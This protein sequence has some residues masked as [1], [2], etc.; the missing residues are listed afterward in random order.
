MAYSSERWSRG[1]GTGI[2]LSGHK[3]QYRLG[4]QIENWVEDSH[5]K[6]GK[7][8][9]AE[10]LWGDPKNAFSDETTHGNDYDGQGKSGP[11]ILDIADRK[12]LQ[13]CPGVAKGHMFSHGLDASSYEQKTHY[14]SLNSLNYAEPAL[15]KQRVHENLWAG[16][17]FNDG[18]VPTNGSGKTELMSTKSQQYAADKARN[19]YRT[20]NDDFHNTTAEHMMGA[21]LKAPLAQPQADGGQRAQVG[22]K[23]VGDSVDEFNLEHQKIGLRKPL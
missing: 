19:M 20:T 6:I 5:S 10:A 3:N 15:D 23:A 16:S 13:A 18:K 17:K 7:V 4:V 21:T 22:R 9:G 14:A 2:G 8:E 11:Q 1:T 12:D